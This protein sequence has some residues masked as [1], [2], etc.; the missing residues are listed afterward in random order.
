MCFIIPLILT[1]LIILRCVIAVVLLVVPAR[2][3]CSQ[4][5]RIV[6]L[7]NE[8]IPDWLEDGVITSHFDNVLNLLIVPLIAIDLFEEQH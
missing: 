1:F 2:L 7:V 8:V 6:G 3:E 4:V 5:G